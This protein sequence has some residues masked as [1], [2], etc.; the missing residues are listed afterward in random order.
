MDSN[1]IMN[2]PS[3]PNKSLKRL[4]REAKQEKKDA[5]KRTQEER[6]QEVDK[7]M[8]KF[9]ELGIPEIMLGQFPMITKQ[10]IELGVSASGVIPIPDINRELIYLLSN[11]RRHQCASMLKAL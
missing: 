10:F 11:N 8:D 1:S 4:A 2:K 3:I 7:I 9:I 5:T 6:Q